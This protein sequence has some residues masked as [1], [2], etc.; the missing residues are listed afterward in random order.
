[1][2]THI[3]ANMDLNAKASGRSKIDC[4]LAL[5]PDFLTPEESF[6]SCVMSPLPQGGG[7]CDLLI[8]YSNKV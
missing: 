7:I 4:G 5:A 1:M 8:L 6:C 3:S 2:C